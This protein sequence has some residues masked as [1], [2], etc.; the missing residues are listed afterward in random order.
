MDFHAAGRVPRPECLSRACGR[1][2]WVAACGILQ[3][4]D[5][6]GG[7]ERLASEPRSL[8]GAIRDDAESGGLV[9]SAGFWR[10]RLDRWRSIYGANSWAIV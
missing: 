5:E 4:H 10:H 6:S 7:L 9:V 2:N 8:L 1:A 3:S